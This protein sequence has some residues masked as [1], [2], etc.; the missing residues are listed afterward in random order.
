MSLDQLC[1]V[2][3]NFLYSNGKKG[4]VFGG[5]AQERHADE[6]DSL[7]LMPGESIIQVTIY[8]GHRKI[9]NAWRPDKTTYIIVG[10]HFKTDKNHER[11]FGSTNGTQKIESPDEHF[12]GYV[13]GKA[14]SYID[15]LRF[16]WYKYALSNSSIVT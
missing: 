3:L 8:E 9:Y 16:V 15:S 5:I 6:V 10:I 13:Q 4:H 12:L 2:S 1:I 7:T 14:G 11:L